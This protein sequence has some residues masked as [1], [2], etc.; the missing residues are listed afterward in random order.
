MKVLHVTSSYY[1]AYKMGG[2]VSADFSVDSELAKSGVIVDVVTTN[3]GVDS[4]HTTK[5]WV[6]LAKN[7][8]VIYFPFYG[9]V[10]YSFSWAYFVF[11]I[12]NIKRY[13]VIHFSGVW[14]FPVVWGPLIARWYGIPYVITLHGA[15]YPEL[16]FQGK[17]WFKWLHYFGLVRGNL[18]HASVV[19]CTTEHEASSLRTFTGLSLN[20]RVIPYG[21]SPLLLSNVN[22][23]LSEGREQSKRILFIGRLNWKKGLDV[24]F[25]AFSKLVEKDESYQLICAGPDEEGYRVQVE[26][27]LSERAKKNVSF[28]GMLSGLE[29]QRAF[30]QADV[31]ILPSY[32]ENFGMTVIEAAQQRLPMIIT[33]GV[34]LAD[35][36][37]KYDAG[38]VVNPVIDEIVRAIEI[39]CNDDDRAKKMTENAY[40]MYEE[41]FQLAI[42]AER[43]KVM[44]G[45]LA[46]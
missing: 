11:L 44:Y 34:G 3:A 5:E 41:N 28:P 12:K 30:E 27:N 13:N 22:Q 39:V 23:R 42:V 17:R 15:L 10:H 43:F 45:D 38:V 25:S 4:P 16:Y 32:S 8:K 40:K 26:E 24:L 46:V 31:F 29:K 21:L 6:R 18:R 20:T 19:H 35:V 9:Y 7:L 2:A 33:H 14:N 37:I 1:P 36:V